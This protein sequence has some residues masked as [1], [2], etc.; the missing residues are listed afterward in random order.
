[1][2]YELKEAKADIKQDKDYVVEKDFVKEQRKVAALE[3]E[4]R[5]HEQM[6]MSKAHKK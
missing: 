5:K 6:P 2:K 4:L 3:K 1:M